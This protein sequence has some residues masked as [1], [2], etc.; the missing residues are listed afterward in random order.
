MWNAVISLL[1][2]RWWRVR[3]FLAQVI[4]PVVIVILIALGIGAIFSSPTH[5][6]SDPPGGRSGMRP[7][8]D[9]RT[10]CQYLTVP[11]GGVTPRLDQDGKHICGVS[12]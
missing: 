9:H 12:Q 3:Q 8:T 1:T 4:P 5:D 11:G 6:D 2:I 10:G 7:L